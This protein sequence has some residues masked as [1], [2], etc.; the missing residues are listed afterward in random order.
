MHL[1]FRLGYYFDLRLA[2][3]EVGGVC[4]SEAGRVFGSEAGRIFGSETRG[5]CAFEVEGVAERLKVCYFR[6]FGTEA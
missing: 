2:L 3:S 6:L 1:Y 5:V 4:G